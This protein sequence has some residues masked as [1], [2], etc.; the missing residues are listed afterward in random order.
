MLC[1]LATSDNSQITVT[2]SHKEHK[3]KNRSRE[4]LKKPK[5][6]PQNAHTCCIV[7]DIFISYFGEKMWDF[8]DVIF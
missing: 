6:Q 2:Y 7:V 8:F 4:E 5:K 1:E 3:L